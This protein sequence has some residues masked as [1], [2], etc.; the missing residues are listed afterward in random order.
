MTRD[1]H[2]RVTATE[3]LSNPRAHELSGTRGKRS[4]KQ[5][6]VQNAKRLQ[7]AVEV[8]RKIACIMHYALCL[9]CFCAKYEREEQYATLRLA[10]LIEQDS[11]ISPYVLIVSALFFCML[12]ALT[13]DLT[14]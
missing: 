5:K 10:S 2:F 11:Q 14:D 7:F 13:M 6:A 8:L 4:K 1:Q 3:T 12:Y 9:S